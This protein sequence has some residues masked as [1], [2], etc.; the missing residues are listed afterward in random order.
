LRIIARIGASGATKRESLR[1]N[2]GKFLY[3]ASM[4]ALLRTSLLFLALGAAACGDDG[5]AAVPIEQ[6]PPDKRLRDLSE[7][8]RK[9]ACAWAS[10]VAEGKLP[11]PGT[12]LSCG[13][14]WNGT[15]CSFRGVPAE[16]QATVAEWRVCIPNF[17]GRLGEDPCQILELQFPAALEEFIDSTPGCEGQGV[18]GSTT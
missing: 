17:F 13:V 1:P 16:C 15:N 4:R 7:G 12:R 9:G 14:T 11:A 8:E 18:C 6:I 5:E 10:E 2:F 3:P